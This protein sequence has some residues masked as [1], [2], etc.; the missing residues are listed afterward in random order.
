MRRRAV[1]LAFG[2][3]ALTAGVVITLVVTTGGGE[4]T[5]LDAEPTQVPPWNTEF[6][7]NRPQDPGISCP[8]GRDVIRSVSRTDEG[9]GPAVGSYLLRVEA[10][11]GDYSSADDRR[12]DRTHVELSYDAAHD[13]GQ[14]LWY[15]HNYL[16]PSG[17]Q[18]SGDYLIVSQLHDCG[19]PSHSPPVSIR[20]A[21]SGELQASRRNDAGRTD[22]NLGVNVEQAANENR[23]IEVVYGYRPSLGADGLLEVWVDGQKRTT[24]TGPS[25]QTGAGTCRHGGYV[26]LREG[27]YR[28]NQANATVVYHDGTAIGPSRESVASAP[29]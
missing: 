15:R 27:Q 16:F 23:W 1:A 25:L 29:G 19:A 13:L 12:E 3:A 4:A 6:S 26:Y 14:T 28:S 11:N 20:V 17:F 24:F 7:C 2:A 21:S 5:R 9:V 8:G 10:K 22:R 18:T